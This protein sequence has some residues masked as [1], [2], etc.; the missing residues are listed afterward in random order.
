MTRPYRNEVV[1]HIYNYDGQS[2]TLCGTRATGSWVTISFV[3]TKKHL[4]P[5]FESAC[6]L[7]KY[8]E[9]DAAKF[10]DTDLDGRGLE[11]HDDRGITEK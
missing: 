9:K 6:T 3:I 8:C 2:N 7:C 10:K 4:R 1:T 11:G 5:S